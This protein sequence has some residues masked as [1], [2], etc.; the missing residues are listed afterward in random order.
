MSSSCAERPV[1]EPTP[2]VIQWV[3]ISCCYFPPTSAGFLSVIK[4]SYQAWQTRGHL[5]PICATIALMCCLRTWMERPNRSRHSATT[6]C[7]YLSVQLGPVVHSLPYSPLFVTWEKETSPGSN[8][9]HLR[10]C[11]GTFSA[12]PLHEGVP[13][14]ALTRYQPT[15]TTTMP[16]LSSHL[17]TQ[18]TAR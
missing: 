12:Q 3:G 18:R 11:I 17:D 10:G 4:P 6:R 1:L 8:E 14:Y 9:Y 15:T 13:E 16:C 5:A 7:K 2:T